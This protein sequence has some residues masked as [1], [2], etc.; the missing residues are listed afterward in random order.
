MMARVRVSFLAGP[1]GFVEE[2]T[3]HFLVDKKVD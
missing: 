3:Y 1:L 2:I